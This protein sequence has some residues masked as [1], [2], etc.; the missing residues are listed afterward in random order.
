[1]RTT[2]TIL[3]VVVVV[4]IASAQRPI[5]SQY[6]NTGLYLNPALVGEEKDITFQANYRSQWGNIDL[7]FKTTQAS[8]AYPVVKRGVKP[9][10]VGGLGL[11]IFRDETGQS[12]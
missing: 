9:M 8:V 7:P 2:M 6:Y 1:M 12:G 4:G 10:H 5:F 11:S 3:L